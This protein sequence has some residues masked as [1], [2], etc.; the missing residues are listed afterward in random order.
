MLRTKRSSNTI[1]LPETPLDCQR[2]LAHVQPSGKLPME[3]IKDGKQ[4][5]LYSK[6]HSHTKRCLHDERT[7]LKISKH[8][9]AF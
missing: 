6:N 4:K 7:F 9:N 8:K 3:N 1:S 5:L 2:K